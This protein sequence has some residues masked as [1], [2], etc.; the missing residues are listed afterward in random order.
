M[1]GNFRGHELFLDDLQRNAEKGDVEGVEL[2]LTEFQNYLKEKEEKERL[3][4][5]NQQGKK[6]EEDVRA[7]NEEM[8]ENLDYLINGKNEAGFTSLMLAASEGHLKCT[9]Y[10]LIKA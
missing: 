3:R 9:K 10:L 8:N 6:E 2:V 4:E 5:I 7:N 1:G